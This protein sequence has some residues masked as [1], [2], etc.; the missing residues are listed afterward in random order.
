MEFNSGNRKEIN[1]G[2]FTPD[3]KRLEK[4]NNIEELVKCLDSKK[5]SVRY[6]AFVALSG[7]DNLPAE[8]LNKLRGM[9]NDHDPWVKTIATLKFA[10]MGDKSVS[11]GLLEILKDGSPEDRLDLL[12]VISG[13]GASEDETILQV[14]MTGLIDRKET[15]R[16]QAIK[17]AG[18]SKSSHLVPYLGDMMHAKHH[19]ERL[20]AAQALFDIG[21]EE[22]IDYLIGLL[23]D[24]HPEVHAA[25]R[26]YLE[27]VENDYVNKALHEASFM[28][29]VK[30]MNGKEPLREKTAHNIG[31]DRIREGLPLLHRACRDKYKG[32]RIEALRSIALFKS[33]SSVDV[34]ERLLSDKYHDVRIE[35][36]NTL[37]K[38]G[39]QKAMNAAEA[40]LADRNREVRERAEQ[41]TGMKMK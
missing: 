3:I 10:G 31:A 33:K 14:I 1:M 34:V 12:Q 28:L 17:A 16:L 8:R 38:I 13:R 32:V 36:L 21:G 27:N 30:N 23:A 37:E 24:N 39:G 41:I 9:S 29:L 40:A 7:K 35:A 25:A 18:I 5:P 4:E 11:A 22:S 15:I 19:K 20:L 2:L 6:R 26:L